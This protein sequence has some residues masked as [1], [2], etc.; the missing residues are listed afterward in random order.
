MTLEEGATPS[1][2]E[3]RRPSEPLAHEHVELARPLERPPSRWRPK[4]GWPLR[5]ARLSAL[6]TAVGLL[7][8]L[9]APLCPT[10]AL[11]R[12]PCP[13][14]G[15]TRATLALVALDLERALA[16]HPLVP[17]LAPLVVGLSAH[18]G[19]A[20][21]W[22]SDWPVARA[23]RSTWGGRA[24]LALGVVVVGVWLARFFGAFGGPAP[25]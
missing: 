1:P 23:G 7:L 8:L 11:A 3:A 14:C 21:V 13:G 20:Y 18:T 15:L 5:L 10:A 2:F 17:L 9:E 4:A 24:W 19:L 6:A 16:L 25:V 12:L 22:S